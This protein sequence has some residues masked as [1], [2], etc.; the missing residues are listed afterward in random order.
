LARF[1]QLLEEE[2]NC[3]CA[4]RRV[5]YIDLGAVMAGTLGYR[6]RFQM[7]PSDFGEEVANKLL[8]L[9][10]VKSGLWHTAA[11]KMGVAMTLTVRER[12]IRETR[13]RVDE[14]QHME[15]IR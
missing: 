2:T 7:W 9:D 10:S 4:V 15:S 13:G 14:F 1:L 3:V 6:G 12:L 5:V 8:A 11:E